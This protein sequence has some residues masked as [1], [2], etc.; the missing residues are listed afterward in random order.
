M[1][2]LGGRLAQWLRVWAPEGNYLLELWFY[3][4]L[5]YDFGQITYSLWFNVI[6]FEVEII[7]ALNLTGL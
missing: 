5:P 7:T 1:T 4:A 3:H 2:Q 6:V